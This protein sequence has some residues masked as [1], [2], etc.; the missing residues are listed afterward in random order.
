MSIDPIK[1]AYRY[2]REWSLVTGRG[3][4]YKMGGGACEV[5]PLQKGGGGVGKSFS[6]AAGGVTIHFG[7]VL[8]R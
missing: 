4:G 5:L 6:H 8:S 3:G 7:V 1:H 2:I